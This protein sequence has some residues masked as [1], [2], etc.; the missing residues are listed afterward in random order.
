MRLWFNSGNTA[1]GVRDNSAVDV[2][3]ST[4]DQ[5][6]L[7]P[8]SSIRRMIG[9]GTT[10][11]RIERPT[12]QAHQQK[13]ARTPQEVELNS[14]ILRAEPGG[15]SRVASPSGDRDDIQLVIPLKTA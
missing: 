8:A 2:R 9:Y 5:T 3:P 14:K 11:G 12:A 1:G 13:S 15:P 6:A 10:R 4:A 7:A